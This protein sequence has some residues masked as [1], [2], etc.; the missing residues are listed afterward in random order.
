MKVAFDEEV[1]SDNIEM[2]RKL[3]NR[4]RNPPTVF[5]TFAFTG[6]TIHASTQMQK[7]KEKNASLRLVLRAKYM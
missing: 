5:S 4:F 6:H 2:F 1:G 3:V 7:G